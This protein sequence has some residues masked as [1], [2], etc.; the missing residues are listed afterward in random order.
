MIYYETVQGEKQILLDTRE[1]K[2]H[3]QRHQF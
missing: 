3:G 1:R 2:I